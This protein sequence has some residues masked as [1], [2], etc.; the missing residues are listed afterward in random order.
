MSLPIPVAAAAVISA[1]LAQSRDT[2]TN[3]KTTRLAALAAIL[4]AGLQ[5]IDHVSR[6]VSA[7]FL[8]I[9]EQNWL[10]H[11]RTQGVDQVFLPAAAALAIATFPGVWRAFFERREAIRQT[12]S[13]ERLWKEVVHCFPG[14]AKPETET[15]PIRERR[16]E[17][18]IEPRR[19]TDAIALERTRDD[20]L[21][22]SARR[23]TG[24]VDGGGAASEGR[25]A[26]MDGKSTSDRESGRCLLNASVPKRSGQDFLKV[27]CNCFH[28]DFIGVKWR[29]RGYA[30]NLRRHTHNP[31]FW[32][33]NSMIGA[34][35]S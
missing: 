13:L 25:F 22:A 35:S 30:T 1:L 14:I 9:G 21:P 26:S 11:F 28:P 2:S 32:S 18:L 23:P 20:L 4:A 5:F 7:V 24:T 19:R 3:S 33:A 27:R 29:P 8:S 17:M 12:A 16:E 10:T 15:L 34:N 6:A 31:R